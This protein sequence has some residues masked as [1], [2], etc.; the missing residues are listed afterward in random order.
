MPFSVLKQANQSLEQF[1][2]FSVNIDFSTVQNGNGAFVGNSYNVVSEELSF[3]IKSANLPYMMNGIS[4]D[5]LLLISIPESV[6]QPCYNGILLPRNGYTLTAPRSEHYMMVPQGTRFYGIAINI[7][8][9]LSSPGFRHQ[10]DFLEHFI[11][12]SRHGV[13]STANSRLRQT[14]VQMAGIASDEAAATTPLVHGDISAVIFDELVNHTMQSS[15]HALRLNDQAR[16]VEKALDYIHSHPVQSL[17]IRDVV[18]NTH[19]SVRTLEMA[20][21]KKIGFGLKRYIS[22]LRL[23][24]IR[25]ELLQHRGSKPV[26]ISQIAKSYGVTH[27][28][29][30]SQD[31]QRLFGE[32][33]S[34]T[35]NL[36]AAR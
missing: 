18:I 4:P 23:H 17:S 8:T 21:A 7:D 35:L 6:R 2:N 5:N 3:S 12:L 11:K 10:D 32:L 33:P 24:A 28:S 31:Y 9:L 34:S 16:V 13:H 19:K 27:L 29:R 15:P 26:L 14:L 22:L 25:K 1:G 36:A 20:F 30:F